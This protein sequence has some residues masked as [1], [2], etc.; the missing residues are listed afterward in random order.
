MRAADADI[1]MVPGWTGSGPDHWQSRW[2][3]RIE[4][5]RRIEM[6]DVDRPVSAAWVGAIVAA[7]EAAMRPVVL[8]AHSCGVL[9]VVQAAERLPQGRVAGA[10]LVAPSDLQEEA[11]V[12]AFLDEAGEGVVRPVGFDLLPM[13]ALP[14]PSVL[15]ASRNDPFCRFDRAQALAAAW[16]AEIFDAGEAGHITTQ[17]GYGPWPEGAMRLASFLKALGS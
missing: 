2:E 12:R 6:P 11:A 8:V 14:F 4:T 10:M 3:R 13:A 7:V 17:S 16:G 15:V 9:G 5:A 1:L